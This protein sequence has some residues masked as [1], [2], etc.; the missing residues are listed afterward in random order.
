L[1]VGVHQKCLTK[2]AAN[3][4]FNENASKQRWLG[5]A[6]YARPLTDRYIFR[7]FK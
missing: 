6:N 3:K 1:L 7:K 4:P 5:L 2:V